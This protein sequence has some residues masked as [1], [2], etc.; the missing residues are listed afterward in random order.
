MD[1]LLSFF[2]QQDDN[3]RIFTASAFASGALYLESDYP[4]SVKKYL[5]VLMEFYRGKAVP[6]EAILD[7]FGLVVVP[8]SERRDPWEERSTTAI[9]LREIEEAI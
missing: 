5:G 7:E 4:G 8:A 6:L 3:L 9:A 1:K 2:N